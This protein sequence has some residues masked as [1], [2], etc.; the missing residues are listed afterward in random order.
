MSRKLKEM[1]EK[2]LPVDAEVLRFFSPY[3]RDHINRLGD[4]LLDLQRRMSLFDPTIDFSF[5]S[6]A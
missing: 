6:A 4:Y 2:G 5:E 1:Q 3:R